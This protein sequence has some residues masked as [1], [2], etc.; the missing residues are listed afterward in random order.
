MCSFPKVLEGSIKVDADI[1]SPSRLLVRLFFC[2]GTNDVVTALILDRRRKAHS[3]LPSDLI[4]KR[5]SPGRLVFRLAQITQTAVTLWQFG[6]PRLLNG[7]VTAPLQPLGTASDGGAITYL[8][9]ALNPGRDIVTTDGGGFLTTKNI[10]FATSGWVERFETHAISCGFVDSTFGQCLDSNAVTTSLAN[11]GLSTPVVIPISQAVPQVLGSQIPTSLGTA[12]STAT[13]S[14]ISPTSTDTDNRDPPVKKAPVGAIIGGVVG[15]FLL[16]IG[17]LAALWWCRRRRL[18]HITNDVAPRP[19]G[20]EEN[21]AYNP[22]PHS[23][24]G[25]VSSFLL[26]AGPYSSASGLGTANIMKIRHQFSGAPAPAS[27][28]G[29]SSASSAPSNMPI[30]ASKSAE[31]LHHRTNNQDFDRS[32]PPPRY[33]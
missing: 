27:T 10:A 22:A 6:Q 1:L 5:S 18:R 7:Q 2:S 3:S 13:S 23:E 26:P 24:M 4:V 29:L 33:S 21:S 8:Y 31:A 30:P 14:S 15:V 11:S 20:H 17:A 9:Q 32:P 16:G 12:E 19:Y 28:S 25:A